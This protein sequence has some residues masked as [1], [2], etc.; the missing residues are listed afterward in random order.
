MHEIYLG[1][2]QEYP[3]T[4]LTENSDF[5]KNS[6]I[7]NL[8]Q[9]FG[10]I[11]NLRQVYEVFDYL[12]GKR[13]RR[14]YLRFRP[15]FMNPKITEDKTLKILLKE[16][17]SIRKYPCQLNLNI[18]SFRYYLDPTLKIT[19]DY[20]AYREWITGFTLK[21]KSKS[22]SSTKYKIT[23]IILW[24]RFQT[25]W[26][27]LKRIKK[28]SENAEKKPQY[29]KQLKFKKL[30]ENFLKEESEDLEIFPLDVALKRLGPCADVFQKDLN[31]IKKVKPK[32]Q[33]FHQVE[34]DLKNL[35]KY[36]KHSTIS[37][38]GSSKT[39]IWL[40]EL[41]RKLGYKFLS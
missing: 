34:T 8:N 24:Y 12:S 14:D 20:K 26:T 13:D 32:E 29:E 21:D 4:N 35:K 17:N 31:L 23:N 22:E 3:L 16:W 40:K 5:K 37:L 11:Q 33:L 15:F 25:H 18:N 9:F 1:S 10:P 6:L 36:F 41:S 27:N 28:L 38:S 30:F 39:E 19:I 7:I 2:N